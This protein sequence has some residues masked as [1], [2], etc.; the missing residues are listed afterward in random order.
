MLRNFADRDFIVIFC[1][2]QIWFEAWPGS[3]SQTWP[4]LVCTLV[5]AAL[6]CVF[7]FDGKRDPDLLLSSCPNFAWNIVSIARFCVFRFDLKSDPDLVLNSWPISAWY[8]PGLF[9]LVRF[10]LGSDK[11][12]AHQID[13]VSRNFAILVC[14]ISRNN[15]TISRNTKVIFGCDISYPP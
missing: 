14:E 4:N 3:S 12:L 6:F 7:L 9:S 10:D 11:A 2:C 8:F 13:N 1:C 5:T 15:M